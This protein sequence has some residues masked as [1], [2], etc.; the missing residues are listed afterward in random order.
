MCLG[1]NSHS[2]ISYL[3]TGKELDCSVSSFPPVCCITFHSN[4]LSGSESLE[5]SRSKQMCLR[6]FLKLEI[7]ISPPC[8]YV[9]SGRRC[10]LG[11]WD[12]GLCSTLQTMKGYRF[13]ECSSGEVGFSVMLLTSSQASSCNSSLS[14][15]KQIPMNSL[16]CQC[17]QLDEMIALVCHWSPIKGD[18]DFVQTLQENYT[19]V[20]KTD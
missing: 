7:F 15:S 3:I 20:C 14:H 19:T 9:R 16:A 11:R 4:C 13:L 2:D 6:K 12:S 5:G 1:S 17:G 8:G 18:Y 10:D